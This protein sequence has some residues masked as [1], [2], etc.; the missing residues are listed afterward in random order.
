MVLCGSK[1]GYQKE[2]CSKEIGLLAQNMINVLESLVNN[3]GG[4]IVEV[5]IPDHDPIGNL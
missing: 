2:T 1:N 3:F 4:P 5:L